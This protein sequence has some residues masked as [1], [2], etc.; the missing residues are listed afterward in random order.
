MPSCRPRQRPCSHSIKTKS[1]LSVPMC[2]R[3]SASHPTSMSAD[4]CLMTGAKGRSCPMASKCALDGGTCLGAR[5][6]SW[7]VL[8]TCRDTLT[9]YMV[10][11]GSNTT[12]T[13]FMAMATMTR[14]AH[15]PM[16]QQGSL[17]ASSITGSVRLLKSWLTLTSGPPAWDYS[18]SSRTCHRCAQSSLHMPPASDAA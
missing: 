6:L 4:R 13:R 16:L 9:S 8:D 5:W 2:G 11:C 12:S 7:S 17:R 10:K 14:H 1:F 3:P 18:T 15:L